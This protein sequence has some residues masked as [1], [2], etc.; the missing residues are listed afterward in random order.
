M[1]VGAE[2]AAESEG[3]GVGREERMRD[4]HFSMSALA[5]KAISGAAWERVESL[6]NV[7]PDESRCG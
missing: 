4:F 3:A 2:G 1:S 7:P 5:K 6:P